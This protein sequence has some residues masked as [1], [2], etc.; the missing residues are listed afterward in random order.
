MLDLADLSRFVGDT[1]EFLQS[2]LANPNQWDVKTKA[3]QLLHRAAEQQ[4]KILKAIADVASTKEE[5]KKLVLESEANGPVPRFAPVPNI[6]PLPA[7][8]TVIPEPERPIIEK[9][10]SYEE[11]F[12]L[13]G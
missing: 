9:E 1:N 7:G 11:A 8:M 4:P 2:L 3:L 13:N 10:L 5:L 12:G 6:I